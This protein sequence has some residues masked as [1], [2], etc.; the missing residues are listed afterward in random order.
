[1][2]IFFPAV[3]LFL[4]TGFLLSAEAPYKQRYLELI[5]GKQFDELAVLLPEWEKAEPE[6][7]EM[8]IAWFNYY[9]NRSAREQNVMGKMPNGTYGMYTRLDFDP[10]DRDTGL[11]YLDRALIKSPDRLDVHFGRCMALARSGEFQRLARAVHELLDRSVENGNRW[12]WSDDVP[13]ADMGSSGEEAL[14]G[15]LN[16]YLMFLFQD[17]S[18][19]APLIKGIVEKEVA[20]YPD[21]TWGLNHAARY[22]RDSG[23][24]RGAITYLE[25]AHALDPSDEIITG[26]LA[27][28]CEENGDRESAALYFGLLAKSA[29]PRMRSAGEAGL[30]R[31]N[32]E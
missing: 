2:K 32:G 27:A 5:K 22:A 8:M 21:N 25:R 24:L 15:G 1:M 13:V 28:L 11:G 31:L 6:S 23:D 16:D 19:N 17:Y 26:N 9:L 7:I 12:F 14:F 29:N 30:R 18:G 10:A 3:V 20:L 4:F